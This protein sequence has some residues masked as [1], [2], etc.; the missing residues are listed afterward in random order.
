VNL[1]KGTLRL[2][3]E[4]SLWFFGKLLFLYITLPL[5]AAWI[6]YGIAFEL[7][8]TVSALYGPAYFFFVPA[9]GIMAF[10]SLFAIA[11][12]LGSTRSQLLKSFYAVG[13]ASVALYFLLLNICQ[14]LI[15][16]LY[17]Q[18]VSSVALGS[19]GGWFIGEYQFFQYLWVDI[20]LGMFLFGSAFFIYCIVYRIGMTRGLIGGLIV[21]IVL[22]FLYFTGALDAP[23]EWVSSLNMSAITVITLV[24]V[25]GLVFLL[26][27]Y[28]IMRNASL[29][30]KAMRE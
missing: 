29:A 16:L 4:D 12:S 21:G 10:K 13:I 6:V 14:F 2:V 28:P 22:M 15:Q 9:Y 1:N 17:D 11:I 27:S 30:P 25:V 7:E 26:V 8:D 20:M 23:V 5:T 18:G 19:A 3:Y 24:G